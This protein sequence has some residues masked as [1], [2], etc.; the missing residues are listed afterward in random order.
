MGDN[1][2]I[3]PSEFIKSLVL[4]CWLLMRGPLMCVCVVKRYL[5]VK[6]LP[7]WKSCHHVDLLELFC[8]MQI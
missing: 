6:G 2:L 5:G 4:L 1:L 3:W 8:R 7:S